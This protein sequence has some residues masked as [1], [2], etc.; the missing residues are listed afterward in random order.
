MKIFYWST[1]MLHLRLGYPC[2]LYQFR[3]R[4][5]FTSKVPKPNID[6]VQARINTRL[7]APFDM[8]NLYL[9]GRR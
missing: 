4:L 7:H 1:M 5:T 6:S 2:V 9:F 3:I 8:I